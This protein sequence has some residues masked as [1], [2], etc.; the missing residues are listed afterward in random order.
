[1]KKFF[2]PLFTRIKCAIYI[3]TKYDKFY[4]VGIINLNEAGDIQA[5]Q[6][7]FKCER[8]Y[9]E[10]IVE[11]WEDQINSEMVEDINIYNNGRNN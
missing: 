10:A 11:I 9:A 3:L 7:Q 8:K 5:I 4:L 6:T 2:K 1:M